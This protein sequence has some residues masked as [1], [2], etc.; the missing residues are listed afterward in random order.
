MSSS[1]T[2]TLAASAEA[3][4]FAADTAHSTVGLL[5]IT[6]ADAPEDSARLPLEIVAVVDRSGS[7]RGEKMDMMKATLQFLV[8]KGLQSNDSFG[9]VTFESAVETPLEM[10]TMD[11][12]GKR[13]AGEVIADLHVAGQTNLSGG[14][15]RGIDM[16]QNGGGGGG[17]ASRSNTTRAVLL[18]TDGM[19]NQGITEP[20]RIL[21]AAQGAMAAS[22]MT[23]FTFGF[24][25]DHNEDLL[26]SLAEMPGAAPGLY[27]F[28]QTRESIP[29]AFADCLGGLVSVVAQNA[30]L[31]LKACGNGDGR[32]SLGRALGSYKAEVDAN[33][34]LV[35]ALGDMYAE[36]ERDVLFELSLSALTAPA[37]AT[38][39]AQARLRYF[40]VKTSSM[41]EVDAE[42]R[43]SRPAVAP[44]P[45]QQ[46]VNARLDEQRT[47][48][49]AAEALE[50]A[51]RLADE[52]KLEEG[53]G[54]LDAEIGRAKGSKMADSPLVTALVGDMAK[55]RAGYESRAE[56]YGYGQK[57]S[58]M[59]AYSHH[60][61]RS[62]HSSAQVYSKSR[63]SAMRSHFEQ[64]EV[65]PP[66][67]VSAPP[68]LPATPEALPATQALQTQVALQAPS[69]PSSPRTS[70][71][72]GKKA[73][74]PLGW[75]RKSLSSTSV[76]QG[77]TSEEQNG[78]SSPQ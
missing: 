37:D 73:S 43:V 67:P 1:D 47:R 74:G 8:S 63:K 3:N 51:A 32:V 59:T 78:P 33:G 45:E 7:M 6:A 40:D 30:Q 54:L 15:L 21:D 16:Q 17:G 76:E 52:G 56:Y 5:S 68:R 27:Y 61:Q 25:R 62:N 60:M 12:A 50:A 49:R 10:T 24:G 55:V 35:I 20:Q 66:M 75:L 23:V 26:R 18:F 53:R 69:R 58:K 2:I 34:E 44:A 46:P 57:M 9:L 4:V 42:L 64:A 39:V 13:K 31:R 36:D 77:G 41:R 28:L 65:V 38:P 70:K 14:L 71:A 48:V 29:Q 19:A 72:I 11:A 22:P